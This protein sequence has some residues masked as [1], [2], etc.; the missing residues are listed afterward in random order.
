[1]ASKSVRFEAFE[2]PHQ[3][4]IAEFSQGQK[5]HIIS[6]RIDS[7]KINKTI[8]RLSGYAQSFC[9]LILARKNT[10]RHRKSRSG[11]GAS[12]IIFFMI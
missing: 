4:I 9:G 11:R 12:S 2:W 7:L 3:G 8:F 6:G 1:M 10:Q 5:K